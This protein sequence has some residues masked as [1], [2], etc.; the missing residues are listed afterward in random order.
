MNKVLVLLALVLGT[1]VVSAQRRN[2]VL[3]SYSLYEEISFSR[4]I[5]PTLN[6]DF[7]D[8]SKARWTGP[9]GT[10]YEQ[11]VMPRS[12]QISVIRLAKNGLKYFGSLSGYSA[13]PG[14][15]RKRNPGESMNVR[16][17]SLSAG[18]QKHLWSSTREKLQ[19]DW[20][21][22]GTV[23]YGRDIYSFDYIGWADLFP[24]RRLMDLGA[25]GGV[26]VSWY[27]PFN[28]ALSAEMG[29]TKWVFLYSNVAKRYKMNSVYYTF[30]PGNQLDMKVGLGFTFGK[31]M[32][33]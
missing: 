19:F 3:L 12:A 25:S 9:D 31:K 4:H 14:Q 11:L 16:H 28:M 1:Q 30:K 29:V 21:G 24:Y 20:Y 6:P 33:E 13:F 22:R 23:R 8:I 18:I 32:N 7:T 15:G 10:K 2:T 26:S 17:V 5:L 27:L